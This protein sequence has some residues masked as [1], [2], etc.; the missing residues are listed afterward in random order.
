MIE[1]SLAENKLVR[2][3]DLRRSDNVYIGNVIMGSYAEPGGIA[4]YPM[5]WIAI[6]ESYV[7]EV[8]ENA[9]RINGYVWLTARSE[10]TEEIIDQMV[11]G[12]FP[13]S[14]VDEPEILCDRP[15][16]S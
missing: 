12:R 9:Q 6:V 15:A 10:D 2:A 3:Y 8:P 5:D 13:A 16:V 1:F 11:Y 14:G 7:V 4:A